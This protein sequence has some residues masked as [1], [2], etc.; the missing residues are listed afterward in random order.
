MD[1]GF[2][3]DVTEYDVSVENGVSS[4]KVTPTAEFP[5]GVTIKVNGTKVK[6]GTQSK[7]INLDEGPNT[8]T[9]KVIDEDNDSTTYV[10]KVSRKY[11]KDNVNLSTL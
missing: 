4:I 8:I 5:D 3:K 11:G 10:L 6:S 7:Y 2:N 1:P 9:V